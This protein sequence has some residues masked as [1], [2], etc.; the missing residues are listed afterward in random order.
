MN[1]TTHND[2]VRAALFNETKPLGCLV[3]YERWYDSWPLYE[4]KD[5][6]M[7]W[8]SIGAFHPE[9]CPSH[10]RYYLQI[11]LNNL[12]EWKKIHGLFTK[13]IVEW[14]PFEYSGSPYRA[15]GLL[16]RDH[17]KSE[18]T[19]DARAHYS[20]MVI[21]GPSW[22]DVET[23]AYAT[24][25]EP[26]TQ[27]YIKRRIVVWNHVLRPQLEAHLQT[28]FCEVVFCEG[29]GN[30]TDTYTLRGP[31]VDA[32]RDDMA[33]LEKRL[34][35]VVFE[36]SDDEEDYDDLPTVQAKQ[37]LKIR[38]DEEL[39]QCLQRLPATRKS[40]HV[41]LLTPRCELPYNT[42]PFPQP[43][44]DALSTGLSWEFIEA[45]QQT[46]V[47]TIIET[48]GEEVAEAIDALSVQETLPMEQIDAVRSF[49]AEL[50]QELEQF[51]KQ[52]RKDLIEGRTVLTQAFALRF[53]DIYRLQKQKALTQEER[54]IWSTEFRRLLNDVYLSQELTRCVSPQ[55]CVGAFV[56]N[57]VVEAMGLA[58]GDEQ[59]TRTRKHEA[60]VEVIKLLMQ[61][62]GLDAGS[63]DD[64]ATLLNA[65]KLEARLK[66]VGVKPICIPKAAKAIQD[67][68]HSYSSLCTSSLPWANYIPGIPEDL[69]PMARL[70]LLQNKAALV[71]LQNRRAFTKHIASNSASLK[72]Q[73]F[74]PYELVSLQMPTWIL[75]GVKDGS[76]YEELDALLRERS[77]FYR[78]WSGAI[79]G[80][81]KQGLEDSNEALDDGVCVGT[82]TRW[83]CNELKYPYLTCEE[84]IHVSR[85]G[86]ISASDR[87]RQLY[88][89]I[90]VLFR[91]Q[92]NFLE[93]F[94]ERF[95]KQAGIR[96]ISLGFIEECK[97][98]EV[99][100]QLEIQIEA[101][102]EELAS[103]HGTI[104][105]AIDK[106]VLYCRV[107]PKH[108]I[109]RFGDTNTGVL[110]F[111][112]FDNP[113]QAFFE[114][115]ND[116][117]CSKYPD[118][119]HLFGLLFK[120]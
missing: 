94:P 44:I 22:I 59:R 77:E 110:D 105:L 87:F 63:L 7:A 17:P 96:D 108:N 112:T 64:L 104:F 14:Q 76:Y 34:A 54:A 10:I 91:A 37:E 92:H 12:E 120:V 67:L 53:P 31:K 84:F 8:V 107:D 9:K 3:S 80:E 113:R 114:C 66:V 49:C 60:E 117:I 20:G 58:S 71:A 62:E 78:K 35:S 57:T 24:P 33:T 47:V 5:D 89:N 106:H 111:G 29:K 73:A 16:L 45:R 25:Y 101:C 74:G 41:E 116:L 82:T 43:V 109:Y 55:N 75:V 70:H 48:K 86:S 61:G 2:T 4:Q 100:A 38:G 6:S 1:P 39:M 90:G 99:A 95:R 27:A 83:V 21:E 115:V 118:T 56:E 18:L 32:L 85:V 72:K 103:C 97:A 26:D 51:G 50:K 13:V 42:H 102:K 19:L 119:T 93:W 65:K 15:F 46:G 11:G 79:S 52:L 40:H 98:H 23:G 30:Y 69:P 36:D 88:N 28:L 81:M 68:T